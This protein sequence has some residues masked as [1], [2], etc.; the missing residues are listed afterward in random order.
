MVDKLTNSGA[1]RNRPRRHARPGVKSGSGAVNAIAQPAWRN[2]INSYA[3]VEI[4]PAESIE[5]IHQ[6]SLTILEEI[7]IDFLLPQAREML[8]AAGADVSADSMRVRLDR[9]LVEE[10]VT[11]QEVI[12]DFP[13]VH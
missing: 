7:G 8:K 11:N 3:P 2:V 6:A 12:D 10:Y 13:K 5:K 9:H 4:I 1:Q